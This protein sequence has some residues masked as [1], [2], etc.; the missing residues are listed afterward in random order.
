M[1]RVVNTGHLKH[2]CYMCVCVCSKIPYP[3][4]HLLVALVEAMSSTITT[5]SV[6]RIDAIEY[7]V[8]S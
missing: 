4:C 8:E 2:R 1:I 5:W 7:R 3:L 6:M